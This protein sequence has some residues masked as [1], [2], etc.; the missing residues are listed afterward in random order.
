MTDAEPRLPRIAPDAPPAEVRPV[1][2][3]FLAER[4]KV[5]NLYRVAAHSPRIASALA[6]FQSAIMG[7]GAAPVLLKE[8]LAT[9]VSHINLCE[10]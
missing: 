5:P 4:G 3:A 9:R 8:L 1:F 7:E 6:R 2:E 10:Y